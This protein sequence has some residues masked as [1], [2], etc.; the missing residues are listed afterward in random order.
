MGNLTGRNFFHFEDF[1]QVFTT[2]KN[3][4]KSYKIENKIKNVFGRKCRKYS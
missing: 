2:F 3:F 1:F 4:N